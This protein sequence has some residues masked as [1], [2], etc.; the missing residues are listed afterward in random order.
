MATLN[1]KILG[2]VAPLA[3]TQTDVYQVPAVTQVVGSTIVICNQ[4]SADAT[5]RIAVRKAG[6]L[7]VAPIAKE[8]LTF[9]KTIFGNDDESK[10]IGF[11]LGAGD[12][13]TVYAST[14][15]VSFNVFGA[16]LA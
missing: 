7:G 5:Y 16:E 1:Y 14:A 12:V 15:T 8:Y 3:V 13:I 2:Q 9:D 4:G 6:T 11:T 10:T